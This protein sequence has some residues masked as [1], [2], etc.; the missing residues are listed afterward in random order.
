MH[1]I[2]YNNFQFNPVEQGWQIYFSRKG[3]GGLDCKNFKLVVG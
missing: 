3:G 2:R 1:C